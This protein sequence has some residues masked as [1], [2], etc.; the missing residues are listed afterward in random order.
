M[1]AEQEKIMDHTPTTG[2]NLFNPLGL[3]ELQLTCMSAWIQLNP[4]LKPFQRD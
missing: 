1:T 4:F 3:L 2:V